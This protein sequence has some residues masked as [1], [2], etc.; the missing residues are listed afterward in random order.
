MI[1]EYQT[2]VYEAY[3]APTCTPEVD[4]QLT[5]IVLAISSMRQGTS[6]KPTREEAIKA[7]S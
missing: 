5:E 6:R 7:F 1:N 4:S 3:V 2:P